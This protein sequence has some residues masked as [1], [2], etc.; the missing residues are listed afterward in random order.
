MGGRF[1]MA[2]ATF[3]ARPVQWS[4]EQIVRRMLQ[5]IGVYNYRPDDL[6]RALEF[7]SQT[8]GK[9]PFEELVGGVF[10]LAEVNAAFKYAE[11]R[12]PPRVAVVP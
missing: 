10:S 8:A 11:T 1:V 3:P 5:I 2:G 6:R 12:R 7:L 4:G 9:F